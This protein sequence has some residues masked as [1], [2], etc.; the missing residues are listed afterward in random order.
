ML[1]RTGYGDE[2][3]TDLKEHRHHGRNEGD[4]EDCATS[5]EM[6]YLSDCRDGGHDADGIAANNQV[7]PDVSIDGKLISV[8][9]CA[10][11]FFV[12]SGC[13]VLIWR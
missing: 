3:V 13:V 10:A 9:C 8:I 5:Y 1:D 12:S 6:S 7:K 4:G 2:P 11:C